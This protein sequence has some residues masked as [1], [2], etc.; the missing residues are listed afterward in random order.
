MKAFG[1]EGHT[2]LPIGLCLPVIFREIPKQ[3][4]FWVIGV[5]FGFL[6]FIQSPSQRKW[7]DLTDIRPATQ[8]L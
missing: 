1:S 3:K 7:V 8:A 2:S 5:D 6:W 4:L